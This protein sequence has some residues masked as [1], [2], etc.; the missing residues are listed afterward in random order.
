VIVKEQ[1]VNAHFGGV[2]YKSKSY[3]PVKAD[4]HASEAAKLQGMRDGQRVEIVK[5]VEE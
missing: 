2:E 1:N 4:D 5:S 3:S